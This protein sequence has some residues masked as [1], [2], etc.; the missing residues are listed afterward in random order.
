MFEDATDHE[1]MDA[2]Q[3]GDGRAGGVLTSRYFSRVFRFF[4]TK[5]GDWAEELTQRTFLG[6][7]ESWGRLASP[8]TS[9]AAYL[10]GTARKQL[11]RHFRERRREDARTPVSDLSLEALGARPSQ[12]MAQA[13]EQ[14]L[15]LRALRRLPLDHQITLELFYWEDLPIADIAAALEVAPGTIK[16]RLHRAREGLRATVT[17]L[18]DSDEARDSTLGDFEGWAQGLRDL[19]S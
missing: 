5:V 18:A 16:S 2:W 7:L 12:V 6:A 3:A 4:A 8:P 10:F 11:F 14:R 13:E 9:F 19:L 15:L 1:L 17:E